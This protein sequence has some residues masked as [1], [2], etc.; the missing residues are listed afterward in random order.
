LLEET[1]ISL[2]GGLARSPANAYAWMRLARVEALL[3]GPPERFT[4]A[5][6][7]SYMTGRHEPL[8]YLPRLSLAFRHWDRLD[9]EVRQLT[10]WQIREAWK[11]MPD[12]FFA[13]VVRRRATVI[14]SRAL[15]SSPDDLEA[16]R[17]RLRSK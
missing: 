11:E 5:L 7:M 4:G 6:E 16:F 8:L 2:R 3:G 1:A 17:N 10:E 13:F 15:R 9:H 12:R 14:V